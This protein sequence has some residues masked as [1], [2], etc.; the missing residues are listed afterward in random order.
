[1][2]ETKKQTQGGAQNQRERDNESKGAG[3]PDGFQND[4]EANRQGEQTRG[5]EGQQ[6]GQSGRKNQG[7]KQGQNR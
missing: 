2:G 6:G 1:M 3:Q 5:K 4:R 7:G